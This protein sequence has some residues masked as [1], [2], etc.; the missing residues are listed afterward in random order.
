MP[1]SLSQASALL[2]ERAHVNLADYFAAR[3]SGPPGETGTYAHL[4]HASAAD[5]RKYTK[6][7]AKFVDLDAV[8]GEWLQ[9]LLKDFGFKKGKRAA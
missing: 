7:G 1:T 3:E 6:K 2:K 8:K 5:V 4:V 9:P